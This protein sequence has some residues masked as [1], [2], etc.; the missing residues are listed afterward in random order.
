MRAKHQKDFLAM[1]IG[2]CSGVPSLFF[3]L[4]VL[5][6]L[7]SCLTLITFDVDGTLVR[8]SGQ[9]AEASAHARSFGIA[10]Q[11]VFG[12]NNN[13]NN[14]NN[15][16]DRVR[17]I[18]EVLETREYHGS[19]D[20]LILLRLARK[21]LGI[22]P[23]IAHSK[24][25]QLMNVM[26]EYI[27]TLDDD[28]IA[29]GIDPLPGVL[30]KL[31]QLSKVSKELVRCGLVTGNV[32][33]IARRKMKAVGIWDTAALYGPSPEQQDQKLL[34]LWPGS[35]DLAFL[36]G[37]GSD[38]CSGDVDDPTRNYLDRAEQI[39]I[40][41]RR[42][43]ETLRREHEKNE[44]NNIQLKRVVHV[45]DAPADVLAAKACAEKGMI[46]NEENICM[47]MVAVATGSYDPEELL[48]LAGKPIPGQWEPVV[49]EHGIED[50][51]FWDACGIAQ[52]MEEE[53]KTQKLPHRHDER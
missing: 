34:S 24:L 9:S 45:G 29:R 8:G 51:R 17:P 16:E 49:L 7:V 31:T 46:N 40:A 37:F 38:Y 14:N 50:D 10:V 21:A 27:C 33:G 23:N 22:E 53:K 15:W 36:G 4:C 18:R 6:S 48:K 2:C 43:Q 42:C 35:E 41:A 5:P 44:R 13:N 47:G 1:G 32:E 28:E 11:K 19:T 25:P 30:T 3:S 12:N 52:I 39:L 20:G 26:Y